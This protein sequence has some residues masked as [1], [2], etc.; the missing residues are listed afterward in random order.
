MIGEKKSLFMMQ[1]GTVLPRSLHEN[2]SSFRMQY[3]IFRGIIMKM[4]EWGIMD[5][6]SSYSS[7]K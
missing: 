1:I 6:Y 5:F 2:V 7:W 3:I 4:F